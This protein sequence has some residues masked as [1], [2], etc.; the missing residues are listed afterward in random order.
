[1]SKDERHTVNGVV[2]DPIGLRAHLD[3]LNHQEPTVAVCK[4][5]NLPIIKYTARD[6]P[7]F[8]R[9]VFRDLMIKSCGD[10]FSRNVPIH[11]RAVCKGLVEKEI[12]RSKV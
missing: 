8:V 9:H 12:V 10:E 5:S 7:S 6:E 1:M 3:E 2:S 11:I 4:P